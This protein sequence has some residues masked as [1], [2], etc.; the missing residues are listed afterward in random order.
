MR[1][2]DC[3]TDA[4]LRAWLQEPLDNEQD[5]VRTAHIDACAACQ[6]RLEQIDEAEQRTTAATAS[7][8]L[9]ADLR[10][11][12]PPDELEAEPE[13]AR[14]AVLAETALCA[15]PAADETSR[16]PNASDTL[17]LTQRGHYEIL[18][19]LGQGGMG[20]VYK[21]RNRKMNRLVA[22]KVLPPL[23]SQA[24]EAI[25]R[26]EREIKAVARLSHPNIVAAYDADEAD[27]KHFL[28]LEFI[29][30][31]DL[32]SL[33]KAQGPLPVARAVDYVVQAGR[34]LCYAHEQGIVHRD[35]KPANLMLDQSG[36]VKVLDLGLARLESRDA[37]HTDLT[38]SGL[39]MGTVDFLAPE[40][41]AG[42]RAVDGR[43]D[44]YSLGCSL[45]YFLTGR[46]LYDGHSLIQK[47]L[48]HRERPSP[49][50][51]DVCPACP[52][53]LER[54]FG[55]MVAKRPEQRYQTMAAVIADLE[56]VLA[57]LAQATLAPAGARPR[58]GR[59]RNGKRW[60]LGLAVALGLVAIGAALWPVLLG[61]RQTDAPGRQTDDPLG[62]K[63]VRP[64]PQPPP[65]A[66]GAQ[67][68]QEWDGNGLKMKF[69]WCPPG[70]FT[71]G[72]PRNEPGRTEFESPEVEVVLS[73]GF[74][75][76]K[77]EVTQDEWQRVMGTT[78]SHFHGAKTLPVENITWAEATSFAARL[79]RQEQASG[80]L[81]AC[82]EFRLPTEAQWEHACRAGTTTAYS[83][84]PTTKGLGDY[85]WYGY[86]ADLH[87]HAVGGKKPNPWGLYD[88]HGNAWEWCRDW[89]QNKL[90]GGTDPEVT[91]G[92]PNRVMRGGGF[93]AGP[94]LCR[95][96]FRS[97]HPPDKAAP[98]LGFRVAIMQ[99]TS[100]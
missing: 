35:I 11:Q 78:P 98:V 89:F 67:A 2:L 77:Y 7:D 58:E 27:G 83:F 4:E 49:P 81:P 97:G 21:A 29:D 86:N 30:G 57:E 79:T 51:G 60:A 71:M 59:W 1:P 18:G 62:K 64:D 8:D 87:S 6:K 82:W 9:L 36:I 37:D 40:Q 100:P 68:G 47:V 14:A 56:K 85:T 95:T 16:Q 70:K 31:L 50:L 72:S 12:P 90:P 43:A 74:W 99:V 75:M 93:N 53:S 94:E 45:Y 91:D 3:P 17:A 61:G 20:V 96:A 63:D 73:H 84:G 26:F 52:A 41:A 80:S 46:P 33:V 39:L 13:C 76:G 48:A 22:I 25:A 5:S 19:V 24:P 44:I 28:V 23:K 69:C 65:L 88:M 54:V 92:G 34:G 55:K 66:R 10:R 38:A 42:S 15:P 32:K